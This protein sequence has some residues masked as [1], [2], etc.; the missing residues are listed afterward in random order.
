MIL[1]V[2]NNY[3]YLEEGNISLL[4]HLCSISKDV[5]YTNIFLLKNKAKSKW[6]ID[7]FDGSYNAAKKKARNRGYKYMIP[8]KFT[9]KY[10]KHDNMIKA[11]VFKQKDIHFFDEKRKRFPTGWLFSKVVKPAKKRGKDIKIIDDRNI[12]EYNPM[13]VTLP[14]D[15][16]YYQK[17]AIEIA[18]NN[19]RF[20]CNLA[21]GG[22]KTLTAM[23]IIKEI[24]LK[25]LFVVPSLAIL[26]QTYKRFKE[27]FGND[28]VGKIGDDEKNINKIT[29][30]TVQSLWEK[31]DEEDINKL[32]KNTKILILDECHHVNM[33]GK[34]SKNTWYKIAM[35]SKAPIRVGLSATPGKKGDIQFQMLKGVT[36]KIGIKKDL[37]SLINE[38]FLVPAKIYMPDMD[39]KNYGHWKTSMKK[40]IRVNDERNETIAELAKKYRDK[41]KKVL[42]TVNRIKTQ[43]QELVNLMP[44]ALT[45]FGSTKTSERKDIF[46][47]FK[48]SEKGEI[49]ISSVIGE[50][51]DAPEAEVLIMAQAG[52]G[53][54]KGRGI[55]QKVGRVLRNSEH[56]DNA[57]I[58]DFYDKDGSTLQ[59]HSKKRLKAYRRPDAFDIIRDYPEI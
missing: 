25:T 16:R 24:G 46:D 9:P 55:I 20:V 38:G 48:D 41:G 2:K 59:K 4:S 40:G 5:I 49:L 26:N 6:H 13:D 1:K 27:T 39:V 34:G 42:I 7:S 31:K 29:I 28:L 23:G 44:N 21:T 17:E 50:G 10:K 32:I 37:K 53:G 8:I 3:T 47:K 43:A 19:H 51:W 35:K 36:G 11:P 14:Y 18:K 12:P 54:N 58:V 57:I 22:G 30:S 56:K 45:V 33:S 15:L 52:K